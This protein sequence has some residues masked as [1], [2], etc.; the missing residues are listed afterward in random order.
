M[1]QPLHFSTSNIL[2]ERPVA[3]E[4][5]TTTDE[6]DAERVTQE[7]PRKGGKK[8]WLWLSLLLIVLLGSGAGASWFFFMPADE[9]AVAEDSEHAD[10]PASKPYYLQIDPGFVVNLN[11]PDFMRYLQVDVQV[12]AYDEAIIAH[13]ED[14]MPE[15]RNRLLFLFGQQK[16]DDLIPRAGKEALQEKARADINQI[17]TRHG[18]EGMVSAVYF[19]SFVM[20]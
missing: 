6:T 4:P 11:D 8:K 19:T 12:M 14:V 15:I 7:A 2:T 13:I 18:K 3:D 5:D 9:D 1:A 17:L 20:Q 16:Y 10:A